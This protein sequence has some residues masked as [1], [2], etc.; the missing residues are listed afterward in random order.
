MQKIKYTDRKRKCKGNKLITKDKR[1]ESV[2]NRVRISK[3]RTQKY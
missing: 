3:I 1:K 2:G